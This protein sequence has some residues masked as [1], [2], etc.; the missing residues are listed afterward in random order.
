M[1]TERDRESDFKEA[2]D[3]SMAA[4]G[5]WQQL[6]KNDLKVYLGDPWTPKDKLRFI[7]EKREAMSFPLIR[8]IVKWISGYERDNM[9]S[10][11][12]DPIEGG[13]DNTAEQFTTI[14][15]WVMSH[16]NGYNTRSDGFEGCL[17]AGMNLIN[18]YNDR[19]SDTSL[20][21]FGYNQ[22]L[23]DPTFTRR[24]LQDCHYGMM[25][26]YITKDDAKMLL[27]GKESFINK[28]GTGTDSGTIGQDDKFPYYPRPM[29]YGDKLLAYDEF[30]QRTT[31]EQK[32][33]L[34]KPLNKEIIW[35]G[36]KAALDRQIQLLV[37]QG[38]PPEMLSV[39]S[40]WTDTVEI[41]TFLEGQETSNGIDLFGIGD[42][43]FTP[44]IAYFDPDFDRMEMKLQSVVRGLVDSQRAADKRMMSM[45][46]MFEQQVGAGLD[47]EEDALVDD[48]DA[49]TTGSGKPRL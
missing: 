29:L 30:Q 27:P 9:L 34:I 28:L 40:R 26:K 20:D 49:F 36:S 18:V 19:N 46:A 3:Q 6:A 24:D 4:F 37:Q 11:R 17:K 1:A 2:Y 45:M 35:K 5:A 7:K 13:D 33:I 16:R 25:R 21:R 47:Y 14:N 8:R 32:I 10:I 31:I 43:S 39:I 48:E 41:S 23:L 38:L 22:F 44:I 12:F 42:L 15:T